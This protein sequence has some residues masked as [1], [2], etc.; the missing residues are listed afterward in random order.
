M[1]R[2]TSRASVKVKRF[3]E[4]RDMSQETFADMIGVSRQRVQQWES[5]ER[6]TLELMFE[7]QRL[8]V[9]KVKDWVK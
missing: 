8:R 9:C 4:I 2:K 3:R 5:N 7:L 6:P 1:S